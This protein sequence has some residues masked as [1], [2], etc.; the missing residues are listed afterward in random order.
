MRRSTV[1]PNPEDG[2]GGIAYR[3][4]RVCHHGGDYV[5]PGRRAVDGDWLYPS[6]EVCTDESGKGVWLGGGQVLVCPS[7][8]LDCT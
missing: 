2:D 1:D 4:R 6:P 7:C 8:G 3:D 5:Y